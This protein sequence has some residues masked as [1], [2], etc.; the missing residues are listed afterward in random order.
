MFLFRIIPLILIFQNI[1]SINQN[2]LEKIL[3]AENQDTAEEREE[4]R[5]IVQ[6][7]MSNFVPRKMGRQSLTAK[8][9]TEKRVYK[10]PRNNNTK[11]LEKINEKINEYTF[12]SD[13]MLNLGQ[14]KH[15][16]ES[17]E[18]GE[19]RVKRQAIID[20]SLFWDVKKPIY[21]Q[22]DSKL[23][24]S[25]IAN[26]RKAIK[27]WNDNSCLSF[28]E[29]STG[30]NRLYLTSAGGCWSYVGKQSSNYQL[31]SV[32]PGCDSLGTACHELAH[33][34]GFWHQQSRADRDD[35]VFIDFSNIQPS[36]QY[37]FQKMSLKEAQLLGLPYDYGSIM[38]Y[39]PYSFAIDSSQLTVYAKNQLD[40]NSLGQRE[41]PAFSD[42]RMVNTLYNCTQQCSSQ[43]PCKNSGF[44][45]S[46]NCQKCKCPHYFSGPLCDGL[47]QG[48]AQNCNGA[49][50]KANST[51]T[52]FNGLAGD[53]NSYSSS[54]NPT[55]CF[56]HIKAEPGQKIEMRLTKSLQSSICMEQC[57]W[58]SIEINMGKFDVYG[59]IICCSTYNNKVFTSQSNLIAIR[60]VLKYN[61][62]NF[63][64]EYRAIGQADSSNPTTTSAKPQTCQ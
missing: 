47:A 37:N 38:Q 57:P 59:W 51:W 28:Q 8:K 23:S 13:I 43:L 40:E 27:F 64:I 54:N 60:G 53:P 61:Q 44:T 17:L 42:I 41:A 15:I 34:L 20:K 9:I 48:S 31:V 14:A 4:I 21:Y 29:S 62:I 30:A 49:I 36:L 26:V 35:Y 7:A 33:A 11:H 45:D 22:F 24:S 52:S 25:N 55:D 19:G 12:E 18:K 56:W 2:A 1:Y 3:I 39:W 32:G 46:R 58:Q 6:K 5:E 50:I 63:N 10:G 16:A